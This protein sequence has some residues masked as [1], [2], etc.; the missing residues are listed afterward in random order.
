MR[1][2]SLS[3]TDILFQNVVRTPLQPASLLANSVKFARLL[4]PD[5]WAPPASRFCSG[6]GCGACGG[7]S[8]LADHCGADP[9]RVLGI[10]PLPLP[11]LRAA[12]AGGAEN[13][14]EDW[15]VGEGARWGA[16]AAAA[17]RACCGGGP[18]V[19]KGAGCGVALESDCRRPSAATGTCTI[20]GPEV[21]YNTFNV[22]AQQQRA[23]G[24]MAASSL[25]AHL[26][27]MARR[28]AAAAA[29]AAPRPA[30]HAAPFGRAAAATRR[31]VGRL[32]APA[33]HS[34]SA[35]CIHSAGTRVIGTP[36]LQSCKR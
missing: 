9:G 20:C 1:F 23:R 33:P 28:L 24:R 36:T 29:A 26:K 30:P 8:R 11:L 25:C 10:E 4:T 2:T 18:K 27:W 16:G 21:Q 13:A 35:S 31:Q 14:G 15:R 12:G 19:A 3:T 7:S 17:G 34:A 6:V 22:P 5:F 32:G